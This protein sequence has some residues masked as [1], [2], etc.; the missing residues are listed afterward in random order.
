VH[1]DR[2]VRVE[3]GRPVLEVLLQV[4]NAQIRFRREGDRWKGRIRVTLLLDRVPTDSLF[5]PRSQRFQRVFTFEESREGDLTSRLRYRIIR[6]RFPI[7]PGRYRLR[8]RV[9]DLQRREMTLVGLVRGKYRTTDLE[10]WEFEVTP[11]DTTRLVAGDP[12]F[13][14]RDPEARWVA[15][16]SRLYGLY[17]DTLGVE[18]EVYLPAPLTLEAGGAWRLRVLDEG[19]GTAL[20]TPWDT[21]EALPPEVARP[22]RWRPLRLL[23]WLSVDPLPAG[24]YT[25]YGEFWVR[26]RGTYRF[27]QGSFAVAW[28]MRSWAAPLRDLLAEARFILEPDA[29]EAF[30]RLDPGRQEKL[31]DE[32]WAKVDPD[33]ATPVNEAYRE[34]QRR[35]A[36][37]NEHYADYQQGAFTDRG[38]IYLRYGPPDEIITDVVPINRE[39]LAD[40]L[41]KLEDRFR[42]VSFSTH[43]AHAPTSFQSRQVIYD[44]HRI[45][46]VGEQGNVG[47]PYELWIYDRG[48]APLL[49]RDRSLAADIGLRFIF[50]DR[51]GF[52]RYTLESSSS[53]LDRDLGR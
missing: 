12:V 6:Q 7:D 34:F 41:E 29:F 23:S 2:A 28:E 3:R 44:P 50:V 32:A 22:G 45:G 14:A 39:S 8:V 15:N 25:L 33:P 47:Y 31:L 10:P 1:L 19:G 53:L 35:L 4:E 51:E 42:P 27:R 24:R 43:G 30:R 26:G 49:P 16:P 11:L 38:M 36:Y 48:G 40:A 20:E 9:E 18:E 17:R 13:M 46:R 5:A 21:L 37:V 52:G